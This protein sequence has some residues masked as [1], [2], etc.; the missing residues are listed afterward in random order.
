MSHF[1]INIHKCNYFG[2]KISCY[3]LLF[4]LTFDFVFWLLIW[5]FVGSLETLSFHKHSTAMDNVQV[6][7]L[8]GSTVRRHRDG[9]GREAAF[10]A[11]VSPVISRDG[12]ILFVSDEHALRA[13]HLDTGIAATP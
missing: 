2:L 11:A 13:I 10:I 1:I 3:L 8:A 7:T 6:V 9:S 4:V 5:T 12:R